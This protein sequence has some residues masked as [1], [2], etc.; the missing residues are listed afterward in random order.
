MSDGVGPVSPIGRM[1]Q[2]GAAQGVRVVSGGS[3]G[4][5]SAMSGGATSAL[6]R[7]NDVITLSRAAMDE[8]GNDIRG[9]VE[10]IVSRNPDIGNEVIEKWLQKQGASLK[11]L[12]N[13]SGQKLLHIK[14]LLS[15]ALNGVKNEASTVIRQISA[16]IHIANAARE[17]LK[18]IKDVIN[19]LKGQ[20]GVKN[21]LD[22]WRAIQGNLTG[23][24]EELQGSNVSVNIID[25][26]FKGTIKLTDKS[27]SRLLSKLD[28]GKLQQLKAA[29]MNSVRVSTA[30]IR[31]GKQVIQG[32]ALFL[33]GQQLK[34]LIP[35]AGA[36]GKTIAAV[37]G[38]AGAL[39]AAATVGWFVGRLAGEN[40]QIDGVMTLDSIAQQ[41]CANNMPNN[42]F[43]GVEQPVIEWGDSA[44]KYLNKNK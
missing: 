40:I 39:G 12:Q 42:N 37:V 26:M 33:A 10:K 3:G 43:I 8:L 15:Q 24:Q 38:R 29:L 36:L 25:N 19:G 6:Q 35:A 14:N 2:Q 44:Q 28:V 11:N 41:M 32:P 22:V 5:T 18:G 20:L 23:V 31:Q 27:L 9:Y 17:Q 13:L 21:S 16:R 34:C 7:G 1:W 30:T 4:G